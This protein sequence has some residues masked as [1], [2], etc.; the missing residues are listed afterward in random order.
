MNDANAAPSVRTGHGTKRRATRSGSLRDQRVSDSTRE[1]ADEQ[2][3]R[4]SVTGLCE[5][6]RAAQASDSREWSQTWAGLPASQRPP[7]EDHTARTSTSD[8]RRMEDGGRPTDRQ[9]VRL[10]RETGS[11]VVRRISR[12]S[13]RHGGRFHSQFDHAGPGQRRLRIRRCLVAPRPVTGRLRGRWTPVGRQDGDVIATPGLSCSGRENEH[14]AEQRDCPNQ[15]RPVADRKSVHR[16]KSRIPRRHG[17]NNREV[18]RFC[19]PPSCHDLSQTPPLTQT[20]R[21]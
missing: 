3:G 5:A 7:T 8:A 14:P 17:G 4:S 11:E 6:G 16:R 13:D 9:A 21:K 1:R 20:F 19:G 10:G 18:N 15:P 2:C 12:V